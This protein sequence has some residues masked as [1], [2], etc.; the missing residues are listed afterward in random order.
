MAPQICPVTAAAAEGRMWPLTMGWREPAPGP[1]WML[2]WGWEGKIHTDGKQAKITHFNAAFVLKLAI[3]S[4]FKDRGPVLLYLSN[5]KMRGMSMHCWMLGGRTVLCLWE[6]CNKASLLGEP[7]LLPSFAAQVIKLAPDT[8]SSHWETE[9]G[10][11]L[12]FCQVFVLFLPH[13]LFFL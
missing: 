6:T 7:E 5:W 4:V 11:E 3:F 2:L 1:P 8:C 10:G 12:L 13:P 9:E